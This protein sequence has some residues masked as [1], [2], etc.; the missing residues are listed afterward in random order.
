MRLKIQSAE[1]E[2]IRVLDVPD[3]D[4]EW[5]FGRSPT[6]TVVLEGAGISRRHARLSR[7]GTDEVLMIIKQFV[8]DLPIIKTQ[9]VGHGTDSCAVE[10][11]KYYSF[12]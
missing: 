6:C 11:G 2:A 5:T 9:F 1:A 3:G 12:E 4:F 7:S 8:G 10:I